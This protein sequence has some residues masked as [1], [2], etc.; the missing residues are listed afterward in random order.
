MTSAEYLVRIVNPARAFVLASACLVAS[1]CNEP[2]SGPSAASSAAPAAPARSAATS[3][4]A[5]PPPADESAAPKASPPAVTAFGPDITKSAVEAINASH[6][7]EFNQPHYALDGKSTTSWSAPGDSKPWL[8]VTLLPGTKVDGIELSGQRT[9]K[10]GALERWTA[11]AVMKRVRVVWDGGEGEL[12]FA[13][14][15]DKGVRKKLPIGAATRKL[16]LE[17]LEA[18]LGEKSNDID[19]DELGIFGAAPES[20]PRDPKGLNGLCRAARVIVRFDGGTVVGGDWTDED[21]PEWRWTF[22][23][24]SMRVDDGEWHTLGV[25]YAEDAERLEDGQKVLK[26]ANVGKLFR[27]RVS[28]EGFEV[29]RDGIKG[30]GKCGAK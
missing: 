1:A 6:G 7:Y 3:A 18:D 2:S 5:A 24:I 10:S 16:R 13:R 11:N 9:G 23:P 12:T 19:I 25:R 8:E 28:P 30:T 22:F 20:K 4:A 21:N 14:A 27:F 29:E 26:T 17:V 15:T